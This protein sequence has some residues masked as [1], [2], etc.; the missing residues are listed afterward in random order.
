MHAEDDDE[1]DGDDDDNDPENSLLQ[2]LEEDP[3]FHLADYHFSEAQLDWIKKHYRHSG[4]F[5][6]SYGLKAFD[7]ED[8]KEGVA[9]AKA[10]M[11]ADD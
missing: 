6:V 4:N 11:S 2:E 9:I 3:M 7:D 1:I 8:C 10:M 5:L